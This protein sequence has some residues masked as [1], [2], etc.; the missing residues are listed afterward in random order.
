MNYPNLCQLARHS[1]W[2][3]QMFSVCECPYE[4]RAKRGKYIIELDSCKIIKKITVLWEDGG[5][6]AMGKLFF[7]EGE[8]TF[9]LG[10]KNVPDTLS[11]DSW[12]D[13]YYPASQYTKAWIEIFGACAHIFSVNVVYKVLLN[14]HK[15]SFYLLN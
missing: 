3:R 1:Y 4:L 15:Q 14:Q 6:G 11:E 9:S 13:M 8:Y 12:I 7:K 2:E 5:S 10:K